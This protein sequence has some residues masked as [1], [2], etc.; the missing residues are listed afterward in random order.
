MEVAG[1][2]LI[3]DGDVNEIEPESFTLLQKC[4]MF[5]LNDSVMLASWQSSA[6][7]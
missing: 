1:R 3:H 7:K 6:N 5:L 2:Y 4:H